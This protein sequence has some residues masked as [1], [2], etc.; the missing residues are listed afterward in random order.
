MNKKN[1]NNDNLWVDLNETRNDNQF[2]FLQI[3]KEDNE[4]ILKAH[5]ALNNVLHNKIH[6]QETIK[7]KLSDEGTMKT[8]SY[9]RKARKLNFAEY[10]T[11]SSSGGSVRKNT[12]KYNTSESSDSERIKKNSKHYEEITGEFKK[13]KPPIFNGEVEIGEAEAWLF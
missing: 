5:E 3:L 7:N 9:K 1:I 8:T 6:D 2:E 13:I 12:Q 11:D 4:R 10:E